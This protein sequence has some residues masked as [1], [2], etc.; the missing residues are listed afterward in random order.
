MAENVYEKLRE[1]LD[2]LAMGYPKT[3]SGVEIKIL[4][5]IYT[6]EEAGLAL[7]LKLLPETPDKIASRTGS[8]EAELAD[9]LYALSRKGGIYRTRRGESLAYSILPY[10]PGIYELQLGNL[11]K[12]FVELHEE[13]TRQGLIKEVFTSEKPYF[14]VI[15]T[16][17]EIPTQL[18]V[19]PYESVAGMIER[20]TKVGV[21]DCICRVEKKLLGEGCDKP[22]NACMMF[23]EI[24]DFYIENEL[25]REVSKEEAKKLLDE[26]EEAGLVH[27]SMNTFSDHRAICNCCGCCCGI[28][29][30]INE[31]NHPEAVAKSNFYAEI[32]ADSCTACEICVDRCQVEAITCD[33]DYAVVA[34]ERCIGCGLCVSPCPSESISFLRIPEEEFGEPSKNIPNLFMDI[35]KEKD[36]PFTI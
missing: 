24:A 10:V 29:R 18:E 5:K 19:F 1:R 28:L 35:S 30:G 9:K 7:E 27:C 21:A 2:T 22:V 31:H 33:D 17:K 26:A 4:K 3:D 14:K 32:D 34:K 15:P 12:E 8:D 13:Y 20:A 16:E 25:A 11:D 23:S 6:E 36:R